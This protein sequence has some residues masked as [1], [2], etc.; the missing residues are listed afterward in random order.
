MVKN[1]TKSKLMSAIV[2]ESDGRWAAPLRRELP[3]GISLVEIRSLSELWPLLPGCP[4]AV[5]ILELMAEKKQQL[6]AALLRIDREFSQVM[7]IV[8][9]DRK[10]SAWED[11][12]RE[13]GAAHFI[14]SPRRSSEL[15]E[16][17][18]RRMC[19]LA[20]VAG[21]GGEENLSV[22]ERIFATLPWA[23]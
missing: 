4:G 3:Q 1:Q 18:K 20:A 11:A 5:V 15:G 8:V 19:G 14:A 23:E 7:P 12:A 16:T 2:C 13:A 9:A 17:V 6:V 10:L 21:A 22:E